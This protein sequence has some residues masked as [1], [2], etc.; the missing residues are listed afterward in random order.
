MIMLHMK[1]LMMTISLW[2]SMRVQ[3][4][5]EDKKEDEENDTNNNNNANNTNKLIA[6]T[7]FT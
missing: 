3:L 2:K 5:K 4:G 1:Q 7:N 6:H